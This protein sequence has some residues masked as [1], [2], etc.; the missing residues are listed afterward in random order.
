MTVNDR[1]N[2]VMLGVTVGLA[3]HFRRSIVYYLV[4]LAGITCIIWLLSRKKGFGAGDI[5][6]FRWTFYGF[7]IISPATFLWFILILS[8]LT[9][10]T[11][12]LK[13]F[14]FHYR[15]PTPYFPVILASFI[16]T[17]FLFRLY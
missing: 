11:N 13:R 17:C 7:G 4:I 15:K 6:A 14:I 10:F 5:S 16:L 9:V 8:V 1:L 12:G 2:Y 3:S